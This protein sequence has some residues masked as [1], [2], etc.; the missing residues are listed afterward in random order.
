M[1]R[2]QALNYQALASRL[3]SPHYSGEIKK[4][5][6][7]SGEAAVQ[8]LWR[9]GISGDLPVLLVR[10]YDMSDLALVKNILL[11]H[12]YLKYK[13]IAHD[14]VLLNEY[15]SSYIKSFED[16]VDFLVR[17]NQSPLSKTAS[18][19]VLHIRSSHVIP[20]DKENL[21][22]LANLMLDSKQGTLEQQILAITQ[23][24]SKT[25]FT[26]LKTTKKIISSG[27][28]I[29]PDLTKL[30][31]YNSF[32]G[33]AEKERE[34]VL[35]VNYSKS[36]YTPSPWV[37]IVANN[38]IGFVITE[39]GSSYTWLL[40]SYDN[41][42]TKRIDDPLLD[43]SSEIFYIRDEETGE[44]WNP[45]PLPL[46]SNHTYTIKH[47]LGYSKIEHT[48]RGIEQ[49]M[50]SFVP[51]SD[52]I[53]VVKFTFKNTTS[54]TKKLSLT[55]YFEMS[56][57]GASREY[58]KDYL[59]TVVDKET[60]T[61]ITRNIYNESFKNTVAF[62]DLN[63]GD[64]FITNDREEFLGKGGEATNP[65]AMKRAKLSNHIHEDVDH[66]NALQTF[67]DL[68]PGKEI[69]IIT[70][71]GGAHSVLEAQKL[72]QKY[73]SLAHCG[74]A[75]RNLR[76]NW[77]NILNKIQINTPDESINTLFNERLLYQVISSRLLAR[78]GYY[79]PSGAYGFRD[80]LQDSLSLIWSNP[81]VTKK[82]ILKASRHQFLEGDGMNWWHDHNNF[83]IRTAFSDHQAW[84]PYVVSSYVEITG[85]VKIL[86]EKESYVKA[87]LLDFINNPTW[88]GVPEVDPHKHDIYDHC[89]R[90][91]EKTF[92]FGR[93]GL[94]IIGNGDWNDGLN[95]VGE[96]GFGESVWLGW[97]LCAV[98][99]KF[100]PYIK[101]RGDHERV[102]RYEQTVKNL[103]HSLE[104]NAW[105]GKWY[106]RAFFDSGASLGSNSNKEFKIDSI[107][108]SWSVLSHAAREDRSKTAM[109]SVIKN[110][111]QD[112]LLL[113]ISPAVRDSQMDPGYIKDYPAGVREN[114]A[115]YN[116]AALWSAQAFAEL[117]DP[118][119][120]MKVL[121]S[122]NPI[123][124]S[125]D[126]IKTS[127]YRVEPYVVASDIYAKPAEAGRGGWTW[128]TGSAGVMYRTILESMLGLK[129]KGDK[130]EI[131]PCIPNEWMDFSVIYTYK[132][133][134]YSIYV[135]N[136]SNSFANFPST[137]K[138]ILKQV[139]V[140][141]ETLTNHIIHLVDDEKV[142][143][144]E[145]RL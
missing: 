22:S 86:D 130:M 109:S 47:G 95:K 145:V 5:V 25:P 97:F 64:S 92:V 87:P 125:S 88:A 46:K 106:K 82:I 124:R 32:G 89:L 70:L 28:D 108:Q 6:Q 91:L 69:E 85:D 7:E 102:K 144:I 14:L 100:I 44:F 134:K 75:L 51:E 48:S 103:K 37:N 99:E 61:L 126:M 49:S 13:G 140:D 143:D 112:N 50:L 33:F 24:N 1:S 55:G 12:K 58:T 138:E 40:D 57:G 66:C 122:V 141:G 113:L 80:Q 60:R 127:L 54:V 81:E 34:Y 38:D 15:P 123:K 53:K 65:L 63:G 105:D 121:D 94:P 133:T 27:K 73:R 71:L 10:F 114:G 128:Y 107:S 76:H 68:E 111:F 129:V 93:N 118:V 26:Y 30:K 36:L 83:G 41:R 3:L 116:H 77:D 132:N 84:L 101:H 110:L 79:Q 117:K 21:M 9:M 96:K 90:A 39:N 104:K 11:C 62:V 45:T 18:G 137:K 17:Y 98:I 131:N 139:K 2:E 78:T 4:M 74:Y 56:L 59:K 31:F 35:N 52:S 29:F 119:S 19:R 72:V 16:E 135:L 8:T 67:F 142:H 115:Q 120:M 20:K 23:S 42:L 43:K 136:H